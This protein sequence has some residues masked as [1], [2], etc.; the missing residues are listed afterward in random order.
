MSICKTSVVRHVLEVLGCMLFGFIISHCSTGCKPVQTP[1][2]IEAA[3]AAEL[4]G[5]VEKAKTREEADDC[6]KQVNLRYGLCNQQDWPRI[7][8]DCP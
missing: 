2:E 6:R 7:T 5:C 4:L 1:G 8:P 3:Y